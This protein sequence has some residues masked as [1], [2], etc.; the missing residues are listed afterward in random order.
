MCK[1]SVDWKG[2][3]R[4]RRSREP[5]KR[6]AQLNATHSHGRTVCPSEREREKMEWN[7]TKCKEMK[8]NEGRRE[9]WRE[10]KTYTSGEEHFWIP[11]FILPFFVQKFDTKMRCMELIAIT[12]NFGVLQP[13]CGTMVWSHREREYEQKIPFEKELERTDYKECTE[14]FGWSKSALK[15]RLTEQVRGRVI[16]IV[17]LISL[18]SFWFNRKAAVP[19]AVLL[20]SVQP[21]IFVEFER[22]DSKCIWLWIFGF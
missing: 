6:Q 4:Q 17:I 1:G 5:T 12:R 2:K 8:W 19:R 3:T 16:V 18:N 7:E 21:K 9:E 20:I 10:N 15:N 11:S 13:Y 14:F 22:C